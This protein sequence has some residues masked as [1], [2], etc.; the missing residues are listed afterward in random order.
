MRD[1][2]GQVLWLYSLQNLPETIGFEK[3]ITNP[4]LRFSKKPKRA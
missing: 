4:S 3:G 2:G 1:S